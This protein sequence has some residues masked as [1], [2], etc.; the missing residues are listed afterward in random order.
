MNLKTVTILGLVILVGY[1]YP[2]ISI[3]GNLALTDCLRFYVSGAMTSEECD[4]NTGSVS[5]LETAAY[6]QIIQLWRASE[7]SQLAA[8]CESGLC[9][10]QG[11]VV[12]L[13]RGLE[14][15]YSTLSYR[16]VNGEFPAIVNCHEYFFPSERITK[17]SS[18]TR[19]AG[20]LM[21]AN[22]MQ[23]LA[24]IVDRGW[25]HEWQ[26]GIVTLQMAQWYEEQEDYGKATMAYEMALE[27]LH[28]T[29]R[30]PTHTYLATAFLGLADTLF[31]VKDLEG[32]AEAYKRGI[33]IAPEERQ[34]TYSFK[35]L[36]QLW[37][38][39]NNDPDFILQQLR[40]FR[41]AMGQT[42]P[43]LTSE[44]IDAL[45]DEGLTDI[46]EEYLVS[47][48]HIV[49]GEPS[50]MR[51]RAMICENKGELD[52]AA[53]GYAAALSAVLPNDSVVAAEL[54]ADLAR[55]YEAQNDLDGALTNR[56][57]SV[58]LD[59]SEQIYWYHLAR[60]YSE[61]GNSYQAAE[62][63]RDGLLVLPESQLLQD[64]LTTLSQGNE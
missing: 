37:K 8:L 10:C 45:L 26:R 58:E 28:L 27:S 4:I 44:P 33:E 51:A 42:N 32:A 64:A 20:D 13:Q 21:L 22:A 35:Q 31:A 3:Q 55:I 47:A 40:V 54:A 57:L 34:R 36:I 48:P 5:Q 43:S 6:V 7:L 49:S 46:A 63:I 1:Y 24:L 50:V 14:A 29:D 53:E 11:E 30:D 19:D 38:Q 15:Y 60:I 23:E 2:H 18:Q 12:S 41:Q 25:E 61:M 16:L 56:N 39:W 59:Q 52:C 17:A 9:D 62:T